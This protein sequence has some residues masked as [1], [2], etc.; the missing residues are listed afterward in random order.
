MKR[1]IGIIV[2]A[3]LILAAAGY[4]ASAYLSKDIKPGSEETAD[5]VSS[6][7]TPTVTPTTCTPVPTTD[8]AV[9][10][11]VGREVVWGL[12]GWNRPD[13]EAQEKINRLLADKGYDLSIRFV[14][15]GGRTDEELITWLDKYETQKGPLD[16]L[17]SGAW[18][19][20]RAA[21]EFA[22]TH[23]SPLNTFL[24]TEEGD[25][26][27]S[28]WSKG[29]WD[30]V[31]D[32][33]G[34]VYAIPRINTA[35]EASPCF[36]GGIYITVPEEYREYFS[37]F[38]GTYRSLRNIRAKIGDPSAVIELSCGY[39]ER[40]LNAMMGYQDYAGIPYD[41]N[42]KKF[43]DL[44]ESDELSELLESL[45]Y[46][47]E[48][49]TVVRTSLPESGEAE[50]NSAAAG[51]EG[52]KILAVIHD[53]ITVPKEGCFELCMAEDAYYYN[54]AL[55]YGISVNSSKNELAAYAL[56]V[57]FT[58]PDIAALIAPDSQDFVRLEERLKITAEEAAGEL[59]GFKQYSL[60]ESCPAV[61]LLT[62]P[63][64]P[65]FG[66][67]TPGA[68]VL[69]QFGDDDYK[70]ET[71]NMLNNHNVDF[72]NRIGRDG[73]M[74]QCA[75]TMENADDL[76]EINA[77]ARVC[78]IDAATG[79]CC[80]D[81]SHRLYGQYE[82]DLL[83]ACVRCGF[84]RDDSRRFVQLK[85]NHMSIKFL[86]EEKE[87]VAQRLWNTRPQTVLVE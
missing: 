1:R 79:I 86:D 50:Q 34:T 42:A 75:T 54:C 37:E 84:A 32:A 16:I 64:D 48:H 11:A 36:N 63:T 33:D 15:M 70:N 9:T 2:L 66:Y 72:L 59:C 41:L 49:G 60:A 74:L 12:Y 27:R 38:D 35:T 10:G 40:L 26:L 18:S 44:S 17:S 78:W 22:E 73:K 81:F 7:P 14:K 67:A 13:E 30:R 80:P 56:Y 28:L 39:T 57:C 77:E 62:D 6:T 55:S 82:G 43:V 71:F 5:N 52:R 53:G 65:V 8:P 85:G 47:L 25:K 87:S 51:K 61:R 31:T 4:A 20:L 46:D 24:T 23:F 76:C 3:L 29:A 45:R 58:D 69:D 68:K 21:N 19:S 83:Y